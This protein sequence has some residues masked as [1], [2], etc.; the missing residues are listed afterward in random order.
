MICRLKH[1]SARVTATTVTTQASQ[2]GC[3]SCD[4]VHDTVTA[5]SRT[6]Q[7][8]R[9]RSAHS[10]VLCHPCHPCRVG[11]NNVLYRP[12]LATAW[13][14]VNTSNQRP[15]IDTWQFETKLLQTYSDIHITIR[16][17]PSPSSVRAESLS[18][19]WLKLPCLKSRHAHS[20]SQ[21]RF[22]CTSSV[23]SVEI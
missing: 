20:I 7:H 3:E 15:D 4:V 19:H 9:W 2:D 14:R 17:C 18:H 12:Q 23:T 5:P 10:R 1:A 22:P 21:H 6:M 16:H 13:C 11:G 8:V